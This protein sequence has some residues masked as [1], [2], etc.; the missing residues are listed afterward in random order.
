MENNLKAML[1]LGQSPW[2]DNIDRNMIQNGELKSF[3]DK[4]VTGVTSNPSIFE[5]AINGSTVYDASIFA[6]AKEGKTIQ[7]IYDTITVADIQ[8]AADLL[9][10]VYHKTGGMDGCVSLEVIPDFAHDTAKTCQ[11]C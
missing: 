4:G 10:D 5:K 3:F 9:S 2:Y 8:S 1:A 6:L 11:V 7:E